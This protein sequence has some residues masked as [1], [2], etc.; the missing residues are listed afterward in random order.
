MG[1]R[2]AIAD[3]RRYSYLLQ[4]NK[5][6][7]WSGY[8]SKKR[9]NKPKK[10][11]TI[12]STCHHRLRHTF[13]T[14]VGSSN[15]RYK[16]GRGGHNKSCSVLSIRP[17]NN[18]SKCKSTAGKMNQKLKLQ[19]AKRSIHRQDTWFRP[20]KDVPTGYRFRDIK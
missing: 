2:M 11:N 1:S 19:I 12:C 4:C 17:F 3:M 10:I 15:T 18:P 20:A 16:P 14:M 8:V 6:G 7:M 5:C 13:G 9:D